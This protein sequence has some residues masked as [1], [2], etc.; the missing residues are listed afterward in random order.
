MKRSR[1]EAMIMSFFSDNGSSTT[2]TNASIPAY[3]NISTALPPGATAAD[4]QVN[5][6]AI[7]AH[8]SSS[9]TAN[10]PNT[11]DTE[12][13]DQMLKSFELDFGG[14]VF[15]DVPD[16]SMA[17]SAPGFYTFSGGPVDSD[18]GLRDPG[19][20]AFTLLDTWSSW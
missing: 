6:E 10:S 11:Y 3:Q 1:D 5:I 9:Y 15:P 12:F 18:L 17:S 8:A 13:W 20:S 16:A 14:P 2:A 7:P 19:D 4:G